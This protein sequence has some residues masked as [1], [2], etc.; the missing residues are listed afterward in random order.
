MIVPVRTRELFELNDEMKVDVAVLTKNS[1]QTIES[2]LKS[3]YK[4]VPVNRVIVVD[5]YS[6]DHTMEILRRFN[7]KYGNIIPIRCKGTRGD[8]RQKAIE[9]VETEWFMFVDSDMILCDDWFDKAKKFMKKDVGAIW[10]IEIWSVIKNPK[11][12]K[13]FQQITM[14]IFETRGGTHDLLIRYEA[15]KDIRIPYNLHV[16]E[17][18]YIRKWIIEKGY[19]VIST[20]HPYCIHLRPRYIWTMKTGINMTADYIRCGMLTKYTHLVLSY[21]FYA[22]YFLYQ[23]L[24]HKITETDET[25]HP[26]PWNIDVGE[27]PIYG[28]CRSP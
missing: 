7:E 18:D 19:K 11:V 27:G 2:C 8:A 14:K 10:G 1:E 13:F 26:P 20:Y 24:N 6:T 12:L 4:N 9:E 23:T 3:I 17:D 15:V 5:G 28:G 22:A 21:G 16:F 25:T